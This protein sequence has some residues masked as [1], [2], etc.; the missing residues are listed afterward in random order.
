[1]KNMI[2]VLG[3]MIFMTMGIFY[4]WDCIRILRMENR[5]AFTAEEASEGICH[6]LWHKQE[7]LEEAESYGKEIIKRNLALDDA[8]TSIENG[9]VLAGP[10]DYKVN[11]FYP[12]VKL[13]VDGGYGQ[14][15]LPFLK[16]G[17]HLKSNTVYEYFP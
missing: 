16:Q 8:M 5:L 15:R 9:S 1:M 13:I 14:T 2:I 3:V 12:K 11:T 7:G 6:L 10:V 4:Q 17:I